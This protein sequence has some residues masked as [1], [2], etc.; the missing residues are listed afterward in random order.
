MSG[1]A[2]DL[3]RRSRVLQGLPA[4]IEDPETLARIARILAAGNGNAGPSD[5]AGATATASDTTTSTV[6]STAK[7]RHG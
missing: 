2:G 1:T 4:T 5:K 6:A 3:A 7:G